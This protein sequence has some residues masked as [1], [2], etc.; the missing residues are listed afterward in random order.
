MKNKYCVLLIVLAGAFIL[1]GCYYDNQADLH[2]SP[3]GITCDLT[4]VT[5]SGKVLSIIQ[6]NC[7]SCHNAGA[8]LGGVNLEG[9]TNLRIYADNGKLAGAIEQQPGYSPMPKSANKLSVCDI[10]IIKK[11]IGNGAGNN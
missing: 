11:W 5:Y 10:A 7:Y 1:P 2:P 8:A 3:S 6:S 9:Y 4:N